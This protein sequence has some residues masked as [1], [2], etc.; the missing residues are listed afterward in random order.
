[1]G[2]RRLGQHFLYDLNILKKIIEHAKLTPDDTV[3]E[4]GP[5]HGSLT[6]LLLQHCKRV[7]AIEID[8]VLCGKLKQRF[9]NAVNLELLNADALV[10]DYGSLGRF[11]VVANL[12]YY[13]TTPLLFRLLSFRAHLEAMVLMV[14]KEVA[15]RIASACGSKTYG[16]LSVMVQYVTK[17]NIEFIV[18]KGSFNPPPKVD[19]ALVSFEIFENPRILV[20]DEA[21]FFRIIRTSFSKRRKTLA[22]SLKSLNA[23]A[24]DLLIKAGIDP[25]RRPETLSLEEFAAITRA[26]HQYH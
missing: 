22:N 10:F 2:K 1:M 20:D 7:I 11:K 9:V 25:K 21:L 26:L 23:L 15:L 13:I 16:V 12:P 19:S 4:I 14:Q 17:P 24:A 3:V 18:G 8:P 5:G 6:S